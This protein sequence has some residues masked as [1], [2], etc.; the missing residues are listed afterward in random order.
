MT[1]DDEQEMLILRSKARTIRLMA[2]KLE[3]IARQW[4]EDGSIATIGVVRIRHTLGTI[5]IQNNMLQKMIS[6]GQPHGRP[7]QP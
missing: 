3:R 2:T 6:E 7:E 4:E 1:S 5:E